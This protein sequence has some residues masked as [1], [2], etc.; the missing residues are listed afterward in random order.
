VVWWTAHDAHVTHVAHAP[1]GCDYSGEWVIYITPHYNCLVSSV[2]EDAFAVLKEFGTDGTDEVG[3]KTDVGKVKPAQQVQG[4]NTAR[5]GTK[6]YTWI[7]TA[8]CK[9]ESRV[10]VDNC[11]C[12][13]R[14]R[15][16]LFDGGSERRSMRL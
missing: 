1:D 3:N 9:T 13:G 15:S 11:R 8:W 6:A 2:N 5:K 14:S 10:R 16:I 7:V 4:T 12:C